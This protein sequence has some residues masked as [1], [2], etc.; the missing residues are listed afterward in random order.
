MEL[1][2]NIATGLLKII[3]KIAA[4]EGYLIILEKNET[5]ILFGSKSIDLTDRVIKAYDFQRK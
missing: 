5:I 1:E 4:D 2:G 3:R